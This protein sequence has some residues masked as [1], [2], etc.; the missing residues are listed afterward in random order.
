[1]NTDRAPSRPGHAGST[2]LGDA[3]DEDDD[4][5]GVPDAQPRQLP[6]GRQPR[7]GG[8]RRRRLRRR[9]PAGRRRRRR[10][11]QRR[12]QLRPAAN[13]DQAD[14]DGD[15]K[16]DACDSD[17]DGD[18]FDDPYDNCPTVYNLEPN[19]VDGDGQINDQLDRDGDGIGT[20]CDPDEPVIGPRPP[21]PPAAGG[22]A[23]PH[24]P[25]A[26][27]SAS[28]AATAWPRSAPGLVVRLRCSE[29]CATTAELSLGRRDARAPPPAA[30]RRGGRR[31]GAPGRR[32]APPTRSCASRSRPAARSCGG[33]ALRA[34]LTAIAVDPSGNRAAVSRRIELRR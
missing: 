16:G 8:R 32:A 31:L 6:R 19:D 20:A 12:R 23:G 2:V 10:R 5:D 13:P 29:A 3:C 17:R 28:P 21:P 24:A 22:R 7:P 26:D 14:L 25:A 18:R 9:L 4:A 11:H 33:T 30:R 1:M 15:D 27:A 34:T